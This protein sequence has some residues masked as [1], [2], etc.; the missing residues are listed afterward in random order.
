MNAM[1]IDNRFLILYI[2][3]VVVSVLELKKKKKNT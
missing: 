1:Y 2:I 3:F